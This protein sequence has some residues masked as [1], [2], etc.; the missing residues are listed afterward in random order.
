[1][2]NFFKRIAN[3]IDTYLGLMDDILVDFL[4]DIKSLRYQLIIWAYAFNAYV[5][6]LITTGKADYKL[7]AASIALLTMVYGMYFASKKHETEI[8][9][10]SNANGIG[11]PESESRDPDAIP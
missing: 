5:L 1:M 11:D 3:K 4:S 8:N 2:L 7:A 6:Y 10:Q 9:S